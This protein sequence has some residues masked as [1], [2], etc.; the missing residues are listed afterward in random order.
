MWLLYAVLFFSVFFTPASVEAISNPAA[1][2]CRFLGYEYEIVDDP[3]G[4]QYGIC[5]FPDRSK[6]SAWDFLR[7]KAGKRFSY[8]AR[9][10]YGTETRRVETEGVITEFAV[11]VELDNTKKSARKETPLVEFMEMN[12]DPLCGLKPLKVV[13]DANDDLLPEKSSS[14]TGRS[15]VTAFDWRNK[16]GHAYIG[17]VRDQGSCGACYAFGAAAAAEGTYNVAADKY[18]SQCVD[19]SESFI[20]WCLGKYGPYSTHFSGCDGADYD[21]QE[22]EALTNE[23]ITTESNFPYTATDP[24]SCT[25]WSDPVEIFT[26]WGRIPSNDVETIKNALLTY[27]VLDVAVMVTSG[28]N[29]YSG[30]IFHDT[31]TTCPDGAY[32]ATNHAVALVGWG[33]DPAYGDY[34]ILRNSWGSSWGE[35]GY[36]RIAVRSARVACAATYLK[37][38]TYPEYGVTYDGNGNTGGTPPEDHGAYSTADAVTVLDNS[39]KLVKTGYT[40][41]GWNTAPDGSGTSYSP[42]DV[43]R[44]GR[45]DVTLYARWSINRSA[46]S[47]LLYLPSVFKACQP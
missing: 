22:L 13:Q 18:D 26:S 1:A 30:G 15:L 46:G 36:M 17:A 25:H 16:D 41:S 44:M 31:L 8:C 4:N 6:A 42:A 32:T 45:A 28:F 38:G 5:N 29:S 33:N 34:W 7:G 37:Y 23:G 43:F 35:G 27:G 14:L 20:A 19:F 39:G 12:G 10:G 47:I 21:Y 24:G 3:S 40:F 9:K 11:C 2:Y